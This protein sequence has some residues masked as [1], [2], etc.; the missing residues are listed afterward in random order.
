M[1]V[2]VAALAERFVIPA[3]VGL[4]PATIS[5]SRLQ[6]ANALLGLS[7]NGT[8][9]VG[10]AVGGALVALGSAGG[11][12]LVDAGT[13][14]IAAAL[15]LRLSLPERD[16]AIDAKPFFAELREGWGE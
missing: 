15:L 6:Q 3:S 1:R 2:P 4:T 16:E 8:R 12:L 5:P 11:A 10:P 13:F 7:Q 9:I 14:A